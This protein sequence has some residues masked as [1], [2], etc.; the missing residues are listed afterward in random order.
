MAPVAAVAVPRDAV[1]LTPLGVGGVVD[2]AVRL[3][4]RNA[5]KL[6]LIILPFA[7]VAEAIYLV[8][9]LSSLPA[10]SVV[11]GGKLLV[12]Y[13]SSTSGLLVASAVESVLA[14]V[15]VAQITN[16]VSVRLYSG[17]YFGERASAG[18]LLRF[19]LR[20]LPALIWLSVVL[21]CALL[22]GLI[23]IIIPFFYLWGALSLVVPVLLIEGRG[24][25]SAL[26]RSQELV[27]DR[28]WATFGALLLG[29]AIAA[30]INFVFGAI[31]GALQSSASS[32][33][34]FLIIS[35]VTQLVVL[36]LIAPISAAVVTTIYFD[37]RIRKEGLDLE[38]LATRLGIT[39]A[40]AASAAASP[41]SAAIPAASA[42]ASPAHTAF[43]DATSA[44]RR[45]RDPEA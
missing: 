37:L 31:G 22:I 26:G 43:G 44:G 35:A 8:M 18:A 4:A 6:W 14:F 2:R 13:G 21:F 17:I 28:W 40:A 16:G 7:L 39:T 20:R 12:P 11:S 25:F 30:V 32:P 33:T 41:A 23:L 27:R 5:A 29:G 19:T 9:G 38:M 1:Q 34:A 42:A 45:R 24:G 10:G 3:Y 36:V 15:F